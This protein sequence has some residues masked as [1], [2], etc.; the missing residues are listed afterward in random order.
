M[1]PLVLPTH[2]T[3]AEYESL[4]SLTHEVIS[5][6][7]T[8]PR[9]VRSRNFYKKLS[10]PLIEIVDR[11][12]NKHQEAKD[13]RWHYE[14][15]YS[16][17]PVGPHNDRNF[18]ADK[19]ELCEKGF[20]IPLEW[21]SLTPATRFYD[22]FIETKVNWN[23][24]GFA[25]LDKTLVPHSHSDLQHCSLVEWKKNTILFFDSRQIHDAT[26]FTTSSGDY[27]LSINGL[28]YLCCDSYPE[29]EDLSIDSP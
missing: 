25:R 1:R 20:I 17:E 15:F 21:T 10:P 27:K 14:I 24:T 7:K 5:D 6:D 8:Y 26:D 22:L 23:G 9:K 28:G 2:L 3:L 18:F 11:I 16:T 13:L 29:A 12:L 4:L 19:K